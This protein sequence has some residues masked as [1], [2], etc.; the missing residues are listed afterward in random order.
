MKPQELEHLKKNFKVDVEEMSHYLCITREILKHYP[1]NFT[2]QYIERCIV[3]ADEYLRNMD[4]KLLENVQE[5]EDL[6]GLTNYDSDEIQKVVN[7]YYDCGIDYN[8]AVKRIKDLE[9]KYQ[10]EDG[11]YR[12]EERD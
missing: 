8:E 9:R 7:E 12:D 4:K 5:K 6:S 11:I 10:I 1:N 3:S 2:R